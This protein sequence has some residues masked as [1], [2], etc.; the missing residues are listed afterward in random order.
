MEIDAY[1]FFPM[2]FQYPVKKKVYTQ[3]SNLQLDIEINFPLQPK[4][5]SCS[6]IFQ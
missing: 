5:D 1:I 3:K 4:A 2:I 6:I